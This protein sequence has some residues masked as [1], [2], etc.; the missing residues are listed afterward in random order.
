MHYTLSILRIVN[1]SAAACT[2]K[3][4]NRPKTI[5]VKDTSSSDKHH[6]FTQNPHLAII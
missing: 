5:S 4:N 1:Y 3:H 2:S 6:T